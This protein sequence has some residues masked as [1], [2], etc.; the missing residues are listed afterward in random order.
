MKSNMY[1]IDSRN[2]SLNKISCTK[3]VYFTWKK[4]TQKVGIYELEKQH[5]ICILLNIFFL[6]NNLIH[7]S[8]FLIKNLAENTCVLIIGIKVLAG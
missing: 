6:V 5:T 2:I 3:Y 1:H 8:R 4:R 7:A